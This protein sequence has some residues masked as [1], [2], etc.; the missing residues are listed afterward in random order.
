MEHAAVTWKPELNSAELGAIRLALIAWRA[1][2]SSDAAVMDKLA[3]DPDFDQ[4]KARANARASRHFEL[5]ASELLAKLDQV[6]AIVHGSNIAAALA[7]L[8]SEIVPA[9]AIDRDQE[10]DDV[11]H[12]HEC[13]ALEAPA[14]PLAPGAI[15]SSKWGYEQTNCDFFRVV[16]F[17]GA[18]LTL[19]PIASVEQSDDAAAGYI[20]MTGRVVPADP[21]QATGK[22]FRR[23]VAQYTSGPFVKIRSYSY[24]HPWDGHPERVSHYG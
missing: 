20:T 6:P 15:W 13:E 8:P 10:L 7:A 18:W 12:K 1:R 9:P 17:A 2:A 5:E 21:I 19:E 3:E 24:A 23:K 22:P 4:E 11:I 14:D 16:K